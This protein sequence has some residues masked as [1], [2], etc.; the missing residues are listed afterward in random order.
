MLLFEHYLQSYN[1]ESSM[2]TEILSFKIMSVY[3]L[4]LQGLQEATSQVGDIT[5]P[6]IYIYKIKFHAPPGTCN[7]GGKAM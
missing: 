1:A 2:Q 5:N 7:K 3:C 6:E 4:Q